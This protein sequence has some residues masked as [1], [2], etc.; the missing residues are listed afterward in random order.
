MK[1]VDGILCMGSIVRGMY[2]RH[3]ISVDYAEHRGEVDH[4][5]FIRSRTDIECICTV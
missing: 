4:V 1:Y 5:H 3:G 2:N